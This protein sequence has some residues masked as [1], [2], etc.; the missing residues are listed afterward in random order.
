MTHY[1][2]HVSAT[3]IVMYHVMYL[4]KSFEREKFRSC[5]S[6][7]D[8]CCKVCHHSYMNHYHNEVMFVKEKCEEEL[9]DPK[10]KKKILR[11]AQTRKKGLNCC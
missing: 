1:V 6:M 3:L 8:G 7:Q 5:A 4:E 10:M 2:E 11:K 9:I